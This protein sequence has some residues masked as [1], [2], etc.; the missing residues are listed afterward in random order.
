MLDKL[1]GHFHPTIIFMNKASRL[2][3]EWSVNWWAQSGQM[4]YN[5]YYPSL[6]LRLFF[7]VMFFFK[8]VQHLVVKLDPTRVNHVM[9]LILSAY[10]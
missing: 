10:F 5:F 8:T 7:P 2:I 6:K 3:L 4:L 1:L 9:S